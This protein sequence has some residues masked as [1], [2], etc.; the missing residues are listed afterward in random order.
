MEYDVKL[1]RAIECPTAVVAAR[2]T[3]DEFP[4]LWKTL[5]DDVW[6]FLRDSGLRAGG[7]NVMLYKD[8]VPNVEVGVQVTG[9][10]TPCRRV[11]PSVL[12][13]GTVATTVHRGPYGG[14]DGAHT[15][16]RSWCAARGLRIA[17]PRWEVYG[18]WREDPAELE[19]EVY[20]LL[21]P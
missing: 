20:Y 8:D 11:V 4:I 2:T 1:A 19:T 13:G 17:G 7:H 5:L 9:T 15:A 12:P 18:D 6:A 14:L 16:V 3:W 21:L 10:F